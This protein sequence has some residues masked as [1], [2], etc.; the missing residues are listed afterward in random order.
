M[1][2]AVKTEPWRETISNP[3]LSVLVKICILHITICLEIDEYVDNWELEF[4][5]KISTAR[6]VTPR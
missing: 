5:Y 4:P 1:G 3:D 2:I 6:M